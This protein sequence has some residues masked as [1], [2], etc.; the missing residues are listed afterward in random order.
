MSRDPVR[1]DVIEAVGDGAP[2]EGLQRVLHVDP[3]TNFYVYFSLKKPYGLPVLGQLDELLTAIHDR[4]SVRITQLKDRAVQLI[5]EEDLEASYIE[6]RDK[7]WA[8][9]KPLVTGR[10]EARMFFAETRGILIRT[11]CDELKVGKNQIY[12]DL[13]RYW[14]YGQAPSALLP[15]WKDSGP[16]GEQ[17]P[18]TAKRGKKPDR[19]KLKKVPEGIPL[20]DARERLERGVR[21]FYVGNAT[22]PSAFNRTKDTFFNDGF[23]MKKGIPVPIL[24]PE[25][26]TPTIDQFRRIVK[27]LNRTLRITKKK[28]GDLLFNL[29]MRAL[30][31]KA[32]RGAFGPGARYELDST[33]LDIY[34]VSSY[35]SRWIIGRPVLY[36]VVDAFSRMVAGFYL[37][38]EGPSWAGAR[39][40]LANAFT[41]KVAFCA[42]YGVEIT[43]DQWPCFHVCHKVLA[44]R[45]E[46]LCHASDQLA[47]SLNVIVEQAPP[48]RP[49]WKPFVERDF[50]LITEGT[51]IFL[52]GAVDLREKERLQRDYRLDACLTIRELTAILI[53]AF[54]EQNENSF[55]PSHLPAEMFEEG[56]T[57]ATPISLW[58]WGMKNLTGEA[59]VETPERI[60]AALLPLEDGTVKKDGIW[61][62][63]ERFICETA[64]AESWLARARI[65][66]TWSVPLRVDGSTDRV[67]YQHDDGSLELCE[68]LDPD[69]R[70]NPKRF[71]EVLDRIKILDLAGQDKKTQNR[72]MSA[73]RRARSKAI[74]D[75][76]AERARNARQGLSKAQVTEGID[77]HRRVEKERERIERVAR[78]AR[79]HLPPKP[80]EALPP[81]KSTP[82]A[83]ARRKKLLAMTEET[84]GEGKK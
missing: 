6:S 43:Q 9:I 67:W 71:E 8:R 13:R 66:K 31:K 28:A 65:N 56:I 38:L 34:L 64:R 52:P 25:H 61:Y 63:G 22:I 55:R 2:F 74:T 60:R 24:K 46:M 26:E 37:G 14:A 21:M 48:R 40:A 53:E 47:L 50:G 15:D 45:G 73:E 41:D 57:D 49:D 76:A 29:K 42:E 32:R 70:S 17:K 79:S 18:G 77:D 59:R 30:E 44:D 20:G 5:P 78:E 33:I 80:S 1:N 16:R 75:A 82:S 81:P 36:V 83:D 7:A 4:K 10:D 72:Q 84:W 19:V 35:G 39:L 27:T 3:E 12:T 11:R 58:N 23:E 69:I 51:V 54:L 68:A 62:G